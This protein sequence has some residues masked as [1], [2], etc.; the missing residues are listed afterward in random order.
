M[1]KRLAEG[2]Q[3]ARADIAVDDAQCPERERRHAAPMRLRVR[4]RVSHGE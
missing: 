1:L 4:S 2:I 3:R